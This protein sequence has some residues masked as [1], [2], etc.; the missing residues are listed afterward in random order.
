MLLRAVNL[1]YN[2]ALPSAWNTA[3]L[4]EF[5]RK[6]VVRKCFQPACSGYIRLSQCFNCVAR[7]RPPLFGVVHF[8]YPVWWCT[9]LTPFGGPCCLPSLVVHCAYPIWWSIVFTPF[10]GALCLPHL[11][12]HCAYPVWWSILFTPFVYPVC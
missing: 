7:K 12:V 8:V 3:T 10:G 5:A 9:V 1:V 2:C 6:L 11:V 4:W